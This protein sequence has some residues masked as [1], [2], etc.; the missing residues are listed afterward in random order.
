MKQIKQIKHFAV[1][2]LL[3]MSATAMAQDSVQGLDTLPDVELDV[4]KV[5]SARVPLTT[6][7]TPQQVTI[8]G[9]EEIQKLPVNTIDDLLK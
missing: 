3:S 7:Q 5:L 6:A 2:M 9:R 1:V 4:V 8:I